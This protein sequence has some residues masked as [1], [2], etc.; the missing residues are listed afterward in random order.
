MIRL[1]SSL[2]RY[3]KEENCIQKP[4]LQQV[5]L[6]TQRLT[7]TL[8]YSS[9]GCLKLNTY[10]SARLL[11]TF[12]LK[13]SSVNQSVSQLVGWLVSYRAVSNVSNIIRLRIVSFEFQIGLLAKALRELLIVVEI[14]FGFVAEMVVEKHAFIVASSHTILLLLVLILERCD[15]DFGLGL[16]VA[17]V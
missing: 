13:N 11:A 12:S 1:L 10:H 3:R 17:H 2:T 4:T 16:C 14:L 7:H 6:L 9:A 15:C 5:C 8:I